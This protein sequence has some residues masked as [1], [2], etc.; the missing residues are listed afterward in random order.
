MAE[1]QQQGRQR[2]RVP[3]TLTVNGKTFT[4]WLQSNVRRSIEALAGTFN[5]PVAL[6][7]GTVPEI[8]R[9]DAI[10]VRIG[11][12]VL[13]T[14][15]VLSADPFY[16]KDDCGL[17]IVGRD[18]SG[19]LAV[20]AAIHKGGQW[21]NATLERIV[22]DIVHPYGITVRNDATGDANEP[23]RDFKLE[24]GERCADAIAR[25]A[26]LRGVLVVPDAR[27]N[28]RITR[29]GTQ[30]FAA[31]IVRGKNVISAEGVGTDEERYGEYLVYAQ[32]NTSADF[33]SARAQ[34]ARAKD[35][36]IKRHLPLV[37]NAEGNL[38]QKELQDLANHT[39]RV[40]RGHAYGIK[41]VV[42]GWEADGQPWPI[43]QR[44]AIYDDIFGL[45][46]AEWLIC[47]A[48]ATCDLKE[49]DVTELLVRPVEAYDTI[50]RG[51]KPR[52]QK[53]KGRRGKNDKAR[54]EDKAR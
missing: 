6:V 33:E 41:Y 49:G 20:C 27:G 44:V 54:L 24:H 32:S 53:A 16:S 18:R 40:R 5:V 10:S 38:T 25:A 1:Q 11:E 12:T 7:P 50:R 39:M 34:K 51:D 42:E 52:P 23:I 2:P 15:Y 3:I 9:Q 29:A 47:E 21:R 8:K 46:G 19:D 4:G 43:N 28:L 26:R 35:D 48:N 45:D 37:I 30:C 14:G 22:K 31:A 36:E 13:I 17:R